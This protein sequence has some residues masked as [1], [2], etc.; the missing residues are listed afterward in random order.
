[1]EALNVKT[2]KSVLGQFH[3]LKPLLVLGDVGID[4][5]TFG[6]VKR[7]S[8][9]APVPVLQVEKEW[10]KLGLAANVVDN[11]Q[12]L[13][14]PSTLCGVLGHDTRAELF[15]GLLENQGPKTWGLVRMPGRPTIFKE[16]IVTNTQ[17]ICRIDYE[18]SD[19]IDEECE[20]KLIS[21][22]KDFS[23]DHE[24]LVVEDYGKG[25]VTKNLMSWGID[26]F[27][28][29]GQEVIVD[30]S[31]S[32]P[33]IWYKGATLLKPNLDEAKIL[34]GKLTSLEK[35]SSQVTLKE[36]AHTLLEILELEKIVITLG[37]DGMAVL[38]KKDSQKF[39][40]IPTVET[41][42]FDVSGAGDTTISILAATLSTG[43]SL[44]EACYLGNVAA[45]IVVGKKGT[46]L[47]GQDEIL[48]NYESFL[49]KLQLVIEEQ[50]KAG[51]EQT[52]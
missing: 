21:R 24:N 10:Y 11:L 48:D 27:R 14:V 7:I 2:L 5:Y 19:L 38:E 31:R 46:A 29:K 16:R 20:K 26:Y 51:A 36:V 52:Q 4:K 40:V 47:V 18:K 33:P 39:K 30:P 17:Q 49:K 42:V 23:K 45:S 50:K 44:T 37:K 9:E 34:F 15:E 6:S 13:K 3:K 28:G 1:M 32:T 12:S 35:E 43:R 25:V 8:P 22:L 41:P